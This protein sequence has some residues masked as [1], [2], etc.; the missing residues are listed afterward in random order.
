MRG[1]EAER[2]KPG[3]E[4]ESVGVVDG[5]AVVVECVELVVC[6]AVCRAMAEKEDSTTVASSAIGHG[7]ET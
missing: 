3:S 6:V 7:H 1:G 5:A 4:S 2:E